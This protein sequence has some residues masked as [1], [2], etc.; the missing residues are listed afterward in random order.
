MK[1]L[2]GTAIVLLAGAALVGAPCPA[3]A[4][5]TP[6]GK[7]PVEH[8]LAAADFAVL[9]TVVGVEDVFAYAFD[10]SG[11]A[12]PRVMTDY[13]VAIEGA[14]L[15]ET[16]G[17]VLL[18]V[19]GG[20]ADG[21]V[22]PAPYPIEKGTTA[23]IVMTPSTLREAPPAY[24]VEAGGFYPLREGAITAVTI[25]GER[26]LSIAELEDLAEDIRKGRDAV[27]KME[28]DFQG[29]PDP[30]PVL[31]ETRTDEPLGG[32]DSGHEAVPLTTPK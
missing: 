3:A 10:A 7:T 6:E 5:S 26:Q 8:R 11:E 23:L 12:K 28:R 29:P 31:P 9:G 30:A 14:L 21:Y 17:K 19:L 13:V 16:E 32:E 2:K 15:G 18:R 1:T 4:D 20:Q 27:R 25:D 22:D 24:A